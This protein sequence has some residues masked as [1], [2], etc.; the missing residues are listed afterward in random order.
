[1]HI[2]TENKQT[3]R[4][5]K[6]REG[7]NIILS[8]FSV[9]KQ[10]RLFPRKIMTK[11]TKGQF[12]V[13]SVEEII[14]AFEEANYE[15]CRINA[16]PALLN[17]AEGKD[18]ENGIN[19]NLFA[20]NILFIDLDLKDFCSKAEMDKIINRILKHIAKMLHDFDPPLFWTG[21]GNHIIIP[22]KAS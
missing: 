1:M 16:Y 3:E 22:V 8:L 12:T 20:P 14:K 6:V 11:L 4:R 7:I 15:D 5:E 9:V 19:L 21:R 18:Y 17:E 10:Q 2:N 13:Y